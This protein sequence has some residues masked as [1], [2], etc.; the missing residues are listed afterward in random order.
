MHV[1]FEVQRTHVTTVVERRD[2]VTES[3]GGYWR[4]E[5]SAVQ[6]KTTAEGMQTE[7]APGLKD[8][9]VV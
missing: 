2:T 7:S 6:L 5:G 4:P 9:M 1:V 8:G 3:V